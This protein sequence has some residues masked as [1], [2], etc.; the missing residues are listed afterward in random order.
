M[1]INEQFFFLS[2]REQ[3]ELLA[4]LCSHF[5]VASSGVDGVCHFD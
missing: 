1:I 2:K 5:G 4:I 3:K